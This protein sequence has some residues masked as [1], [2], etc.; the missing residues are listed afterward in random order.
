[1]KQKVWKRKDQRYLQRNK[2]IR[3]GKKIYSMNDENII[4]IDEHVFCTCV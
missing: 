4:W 3:L 2:L 1:M